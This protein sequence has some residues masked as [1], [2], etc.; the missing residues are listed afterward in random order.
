MDNLRY[1]TEKWLPQIH[2]EGNLD[3][4]QPHLRHSASQKADLCNANLCSVIGTDLSQ[5]LEAPFSK[6][7]STA[8]FMVLIVCLISDF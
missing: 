5:Q 1:V 6:P 8:L 2:S 7:H 3:G 4:R